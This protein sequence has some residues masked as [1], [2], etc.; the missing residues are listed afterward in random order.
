MVSS[1]QRSDGDVGL[2]GVEVEQLPMTPNASSAPVWQH[3]L[4]MVVHQSSSGSSG[5]ITSPDSKTA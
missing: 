5:P 4:E 3:H 1:E 2:I